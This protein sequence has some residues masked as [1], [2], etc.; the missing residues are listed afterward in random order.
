MFL[1]EECGRVGEV[2]KRMQGSDKNH[3]ALRG[4]KKFPPSNHGRE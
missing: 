2:P 4:F 1:K 3:A